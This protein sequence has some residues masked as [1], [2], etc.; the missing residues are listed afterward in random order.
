MLGGQTNLACAQDVESYMKEAHEAR[1]QTDF[2][3]A[4]KLYTKVI[5]LDSN[6]IEALYYRG[7]VE[8]VWNK[9]KGLDDFKKV[10]ELDSLHEGALHSLADSYAILGK[11]ELAE[12]YKMRALAV[13]PKTASNLLT[14]ARKANSSGE[15]EK[16]IEL[17]NES[18]ELD[19][20]SQIWLQ[21][22][23]RA[24]AYYMLGK[25]K[26]SIAD[27]EKCFNEF[28]YGMY[29]CNNYEMCGD[30]YKGL[31]NTNKACEYWKIAVRN[32]DPEF[33]P[34]SDEVKL[35][36]KNNCNN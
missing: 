13:N 8:N 6:N 26:E 15:Y 3:K 36:V 9:S 32:D 29:S 25:H 12:E 7:W 2:D 21:L 35:K 19:D 30:A 24:E 31:G 1:Q 16:A 10:L 5:E 4:A 20:E 27:F 22:L 23:E 11:H 28:G 34:A 18:I 14:M 33:D 17:C